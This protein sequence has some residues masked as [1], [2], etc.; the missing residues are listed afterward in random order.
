[1][2]TGAL[3]VF[4]T[5]QRI[6]PNDQIVVANPTLRILSLICKAREPFYLGI[7]PLLAQEQFTTIE[8]RV[9]LM[10]LRAY[11]N[12]ITSEAAYAALSGLSPEHSRQQLDGAEKRGR[13]RED[14]RPVRDGISRLRQKIAPFS[15][16]IDFE[17]HAGY[18][19]LI[20]AQRR[21]WS[22]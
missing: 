17:P 16:G 22:S 11:P 4:P 8:W 5:V 20:Y 7:S 2:E 6:L 14:L 1:M 10:L 3:E 9:L 15:L 21:P 12:A 19:L 18:R 13:L